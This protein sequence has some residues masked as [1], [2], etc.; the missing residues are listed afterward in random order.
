MLVK[1]R[2]T[3]LVDG[4][5]C[6]CG[7]GGSVCRILFMALSIPAFLLGTPDPSVP[8]PF[9]RSCLQKAILKDE[10]MSVYKQR[11]GLLLFTIK[12]VDFPSLV[13][14]NLIQTH[15]HLSGTLC[16]TSLPQPRL[17]K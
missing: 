1:P 17:G 11:P 6:V 14:L 12:V 16:F 10:V 2:H 5:V 3:G 7:G 9:L 15:W 8:G 4:L 13:F